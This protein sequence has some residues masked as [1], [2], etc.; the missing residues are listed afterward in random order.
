MHVLL[1]RLLLHHLVL[2]HPG[3]HVQGGVEDVVDQIVDVQVQGVLG[4]LVH[5]LGAPLGGHHGELFFRIFVKNWG[6]PWAAREELS[7][8]KMMITKN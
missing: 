8:A 6:D 5:Q 2:L 3:V 1:I 4:Q 7:C